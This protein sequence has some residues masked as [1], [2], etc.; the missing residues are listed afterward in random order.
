MGLR[1]LFMGFFVGI[2]LPN[3]ASDSSYPT[4][5]QTGATRGMVVAVDTVYRIHRLGQMLIR[6]LVCAR[7]LFPGWRASPIRRRFPL[8][9]H[10]ALLQP[11]GRG[12]RGSPKQSRPGA[13]FD[14]SRLRRQRRSQPQE[15]ASKWGTPPQLSGSASSASIG[16]IG[17]PAIESILRKTARIC[18][19]TRRWHK[20]APT[21]RHRARE[22][23]VDRI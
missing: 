1:V 18:N 9:E 16:S 10:S 12:K 8:G 21:S 7:R 4:A 20:T 17:D 6:S 13:P 23:F 5:L 15:H 3:L 2:L 11:E 22:D 19:L 14:V